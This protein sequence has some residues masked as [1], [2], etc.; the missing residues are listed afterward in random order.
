MYLPTVPYQATKVQKVFGY[1]T[2]FEGQGVKFCFLWQLTMSS[3]LSSKYLHVVAAAVRCT[4]S[5]PKFYA[6]ECK[7]VAQWPP[8]LCDVPARQSLLV[9]TKAS[10]K[11]GT[12]SDPIA[13]VR[14]KLCLGRGYCTV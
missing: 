6:S 10:L 1:V 13:L 12:N 7:K 11:N 5:A 8:Q 2:K 9:I 3:A 14:L 4:N